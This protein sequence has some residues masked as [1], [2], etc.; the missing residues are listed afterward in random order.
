MPELIDQPDTLAFPLGTYIP[1]FDKNI[2]FADGCSRSWACSVRYMAP[3]SSGAVLFTHSMSPDISTSAAVAYRGQGRVGSQS[4]HKL[5]VHCLY[6]LDTTPEGVN[7]GSL[8][9]LHTCSNVAHKCVVDLKVDWIKY[10]VY[11]T[12]EFATV[13]FKYAIMGGKEG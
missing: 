11:N 1:L 9:N 5:A 12:T 13:S 2:R 7:N 6:I 8:A 3:P 4:V 10:C